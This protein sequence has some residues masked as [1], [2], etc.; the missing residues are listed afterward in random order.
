MHDNETAVSNVSIED[1]RLPSAV[2]PER[3]EI[4]LE[5]D[6]SNFTFAGEETVYVRINEP[7]RQISLNA[8]ELEIDRV[9]V[10]REG[11]RLSGTIEMNEKLERAKFSFEGTLEPGD[12]KLR[13]V[14][15]GSLNDKLHG[16]YRS[17]YKDAAGQTHMVASTQFEATDA[18]RAIPCWDEPAAKAKFKVTLLIDQNQ[19]AISNTAIEHEKPLLPAR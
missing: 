6:L 16:F 14:F 11:R 1:Y 2:I 19:A 17:Q 7:V 4:R 8:L 13:I 10:E 9:E 18:R 15:R 12:W 5:P 3:Y